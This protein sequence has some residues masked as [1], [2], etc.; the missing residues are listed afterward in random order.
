MKTLTCQKT[1]YIRSCQGPTKML[2][3]RVQSFCR[4]NTLTNKQTNKIHFY[5][6]FVFAIFKWN[7]RF[8][9]VP[10]NKLWRF[11]LKIEYFLLRFSR[12]KLAHLCSREKEKH[13]VMSKFCLTRCRAKGS[14]C[15]CGTM[16]VKL[17]YI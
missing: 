13:F 1:Y 12:K 16:E 7:V 2:A 14:G 6:M 4:T 9:T 8:T 3:C 17:T 5:I 15:E 11:F 10:F